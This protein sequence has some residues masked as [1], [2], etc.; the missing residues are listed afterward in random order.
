MSL[1]PRMAMFN[2]LGDL[3]TSPLLSYPTALSSFELTLT[4]NSL[5]STVGMYTCVS[6]L[7]PI[8]VSVIVVGIFLICD[9]GIGPIVAN[10]SLLLL[11][12]IKIAI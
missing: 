8:V 4:T 2:N 7:L 3:T 5:I 9:K 6:F 12:E 10:H 1:S 11:T